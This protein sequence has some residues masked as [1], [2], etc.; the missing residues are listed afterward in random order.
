MW[1][2]YGGNTNLA[3]VFKND[4]FLSESDALNAFTSPVLYADS[5]SFKPNFLQVAENVERNIGMLCIAGEAIASHLMLSAMHFAA[6]S[7]KHP[8][9]AEEREWRVIYTPKLSL[10]GSRSSRLE[11]KIVSLGGVPQRIFALKLENIPE[12]GFLGATLPELLVEVII[13]PSQFP[14]PIYD[15]LVDKLHHAGIADAADRVRVS[16]IPL[17]R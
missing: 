11:S 8:G 6:L 16:N 10:T 5:D 9:F 17:R 14:W 7:T 13:G 1:R 4:P 2:A 15:A 12:E 3:F